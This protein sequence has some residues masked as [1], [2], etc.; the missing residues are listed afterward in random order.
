MTL[1][2]DDNETG[3][4]YVSHTKV[5]LPYNKLDYELV[6]VY[7]LSEER[8][9]ILLTNLSNHSKNDVI[10]VVRLYFSRQRIEEYYKVKK[11]EYE[12]KSIKNH[13]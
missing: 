9:L 7:V 8:H 10:K 11:Q 2:F 4:V 13:E 3:E 6:I 12:S 1:P 5:T